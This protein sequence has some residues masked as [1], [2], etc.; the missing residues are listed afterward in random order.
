MIPPNGSGHLRWVAT[1]RDRKPTL[2]RVRFTRTRTLA[3]STR[4]CSPVVVLLRSCAQDV[5]SYVLGRIR[6]GG[7]P[8]R[9]LVRYAPLSFVILRA[10]ALILDGRTGIYVPLFLTACYVQWQKGVKKDYADRIMAITTVFYGL[11]LTMVCNFRRSPPRSFAYCNW[12][13]LAIH[14]HTW[15]TWCPVPASWRGHGNLFPE[16]FKPPICL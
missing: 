13:A 15:S 2:S 6:Y 16:H 5:A 8:R 3:A 9:R 14:L 4:A 10:R 7:Y 11:I 12:S 1:G